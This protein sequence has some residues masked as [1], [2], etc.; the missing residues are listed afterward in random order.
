[1][2]TQDPDSTPEGQVS[3]DC[4][5]RA[6]AIS[7]PV[8]ARVE[9]V[10]A[11]ARSGA[12]DEYTVHTWPAEVVL[13]PLSDGTLAVERYRTFRQWAVQWNVHV[14]PPFRRTTRRS[15]LTG[16]TR[17]VLRTPSLCL[18][19]H[20]DGRLRE[21]FPHTSKGV[22]YDVADAIGTLAS[23]VLTVD[24][25]VAAEPVGPRDC[26]RCDVPLST[27]QGLYACPDCGWVGVADAGGAVRPYDRAE[28]TDGEPDD[29]EPSLLRP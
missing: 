8:E 13:A 10:R 9:S 12:I 15:E 24:D 23:G 18:A 14:E 5:V 16:E 20:V 11:L 25:T 7:D 27:G 21:V 3:V 1:M 22:T 17:E 4:Y 19:V 29:V 26:P 6:D 28:P 2:S